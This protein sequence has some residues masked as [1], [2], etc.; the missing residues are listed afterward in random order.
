MY[1]M[2]QIKIN[3]GKSTTCIRKRLSDS[4]SRTTNCEF[5]FTAT[6]WHNQLHWPSWYMLSSNREA[7]EHDTIVCRHTCLAQAEWISPHEI[8][9]WNR[10]NRIAFSFSEEE[11][12]IRIMIQN[13]GVGP[14]L[15][16]ICSVSVTASS[17][18]VRYPRAGCLLRLR[19]SR[20]RTAL[21][22]GT[23]S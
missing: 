19:D 23:V 13:A 8:N 11:A 3:F 12:R 21:L 1:P 9:G 14:S 2:I 7:L 17:D 20:K 15:K 22:R 4:S 16:E 10:S 18:L 5:N 6:Y